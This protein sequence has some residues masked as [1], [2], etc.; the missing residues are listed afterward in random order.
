MWSHSHTY[1]YRHINF[2]IQQQTTEPLPWYPT[3]DGP[4]STSVSNVN[5]TS[6]LIT[7]LKRRSDAWSKPKIPM[8]R[9]VTDGL[10]KRRA[11]AKEKQEI[12]EVLPA[13]L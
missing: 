1:V 2:F 3:C 8:C 10:K 7:K 12:I 9:L 6:S 11:E 5:D 13:M 4:N